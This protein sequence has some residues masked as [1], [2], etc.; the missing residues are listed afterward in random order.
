M[1]AVL[2]TFGELEYVSAGKLQPAWFQS[3]DQTRGSSSL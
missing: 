3:D 2:E 1:S